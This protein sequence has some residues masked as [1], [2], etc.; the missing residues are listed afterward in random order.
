[1]KHHYHN[2]KGT[3]GYLLEEYEQKAKIQDQIVLEL[4][5][6]CGCPMSPSQVY[7]D[8]YEKFPITSIR[9]AFSNLTRDGYLCKLPNDFRVMGMYGREEGLWELTEDSDCG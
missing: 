3:V 9:R 2:A 4:F 5:K 7:K 8:F 1:M 6:I